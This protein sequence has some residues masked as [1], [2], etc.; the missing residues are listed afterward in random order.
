MT[1]DDYISLPPDLPA[2]AL[3]EAELSTWLHLENCV[4]RRTRIMDA[5]KLELALEVAD[6]RRIDQRY[7]EK[8]TR[9]MQLIEKGDPHREIPDLMIEL[10]DDE[11]YMN[12]TYG[13]ITQLNDTIEALTLSIPDSTSTPA[14]A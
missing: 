11:E 3:T 4:E 9:R 5:L 8:D 10:G 6:Y 2:I 14:L 12:T 13:Y 1:L 7:Q